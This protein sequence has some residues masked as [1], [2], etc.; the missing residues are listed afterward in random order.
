MIDVAIIREQPD[1]VKKKIAD[2][3]SDP[4][5]VDTFLDLDTKWRTA[6]SALDEKRRVQKELS[7]ARKIEEAQA[8]KEEIK[9]I[10]E[11]VALT[12]KERDTILRQFPNL[13]DDDVP[14]GRDESE[15]VVVRSWGSVPQFNFEPRDHMELGEN[16]G[17]IDTARA[18][19]VTGSRFAYLKGDG[20][21]LELALVSYATSVVTNPEIIRSLAQKISPDHPIAPF[22]PVVP[23]VMIR[24]EIFDRM[25]RLDPKEDRY[26][27]PSDDIYLIGS[28]EH[29]LGPLHMDQTVLESALPIRYVGFSTA[30]RR[31]AGSYGRDVK[32]ILR[33][34]QFDKIEIESFTTKELGRN[35]QDF[36]VSIQEY[37]M[38]SLELPYH[39]VSVCT[40]DMGTPDARQLDIETWIPSQNVYRETHSSDYVT[41]YQSR[42]LKTRVKRTNGETELV[43]MN[44][45]TVF[46][47]GRTLIAILENNQQADGSITIPKVLRPYMGG[48]E[49]ISN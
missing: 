8:N 6:T 16:L 15:N 37:L 32:G 21:L 36:I 33:M 1:I 5:L 23:P 47:I 49:K 44:D 34:H 12:E 4:A 45:A 46:A 41:D 27:I 38:Q 30:F 7:A 25:G 39:V 42:R 35:E 28:A 26:Y 2:K 22:I 29:T 18:A 19:E 17:I 48:K 3:K 10:E 20:A 14:V 11:E 31:E 13:A 24:P 9:K 40:G 43:H